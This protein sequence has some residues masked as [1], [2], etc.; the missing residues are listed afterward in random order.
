MRRIL[1][2]VLVCSGAALA[3]IKLDEPPSAIVTDN[4]GNPQKTEPCGG[5]GTASNMVRTVE[6]GSMLT[7]SWRETI[8]HPGHFRISI[9]PDAGSFVTPTAELNQ[10]GR[11]CA[12][13]PIEN[14]PRWPTL[15]DGLFVHTTARPNG[16]YST[17]VRVPDAPCER[18]TLQLLQFMSAHAP[19]CW[20]YQCAT[21]RIVVPDAGRADAGVVDA[22]RP[23]TD[24]GSAGSGGSSGAGGNAG[25]GGSA[26]S[27][28]GGSAGTG[29]ASGEGGVTGT[30]GS[31]M[32]GTGGTSVSGSGGAAGQSQSGSD[33]GVDPVNPPMGGCS[34]AGGVAALLLFALSRF[35]RRA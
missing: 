29:G 32:A 17:Q 20:Y 12:R 35:R 24:A 27:S 8:L 13:A 15:V 6:A 25:L 23:G 10:G 28:E 26:G 31:V 16:M 3:H 34:S 19:P 30:G 21:L 7:V 1:C 9:A 33:A 2:G 4:S 14:N 5:N 11:N 22:G 18:C